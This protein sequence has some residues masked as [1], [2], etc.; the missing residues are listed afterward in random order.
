MNLRLSQRRR[1]EKKKLFCNK[2]WPFQDRNISSDIQISRRDLS[3]S[4]LLTDNLTK[5]INKY[6]WTPQIS[7]VD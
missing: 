1:C 7:E 4:A 6:S 2:K 5:M 3:P